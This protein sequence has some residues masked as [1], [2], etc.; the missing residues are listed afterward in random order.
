MVYRLAFLLLSNF[1]LEGFWAVSS[2]FSERLFLET[3]QI[4]GGISA[5]ETVL[6]NTGK[7]VLKGHI[8]KNSRKTSPKLLK[9][10]C[11]HPAGDYEKFG[12]KIIAIQTE[13]ITFTSSVL[14]SHI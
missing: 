10:C 8:L 4:Y 1:Q 9:S 2:L 14:F 7:E 5:F 12:N 11:G 6:S 3:A 13:Y